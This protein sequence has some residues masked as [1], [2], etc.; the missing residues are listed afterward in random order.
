MALYSVTEA[1]Q[2]LH[3]SERMIRHMCSNGRLKGVKCG[4]TWLVELG[5]PP[6][7]NDRAIS[8]RDIQRRKGKSA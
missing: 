1:A 3:T 7:R 5:R 4:G 6:K 2:E 8:G